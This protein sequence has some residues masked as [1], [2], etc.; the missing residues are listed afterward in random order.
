LNIIG[1]AEDIE[2]ASAYLK[3]EF[4]M[5]DLGETKFCLSLQ[6]EHLPEGI[7]VHQSTYCKKVLE[8][9]NMIKAHPLK[10]P[11][12]V[13][14]LEM[15]TDPLRP[16]SDDEKSLGPKVPYLSAIG[17]LMYL[18]NCTR[19]DIAFAVNLLARYSADPT[20]RHWVGVKT[21]L[22]YLK[23]TQDLG[24]F[25]SKN[26]DQT[27]VGY[28][29][30]GYQSDPHNGMSHTGFVFLCGGC[31]GLVLKCYELRTRQHKKCLNVKVLHPSKHYFPWGY[32]DFRMKV[33]KDI[34]S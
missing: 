26:Q 2:E 24:L 22:R 19:P 23:G 27:M 10:T 18:A 13:R 12:V 11:M 30:A 4:E 14:S 29:D 20:R 15:D 17:A 6:I 8:R 32:N 34:P 9:F 3:T 28:A 21:I 1:Y 5:K 7:F 16:K 33:M 31:W 25:F